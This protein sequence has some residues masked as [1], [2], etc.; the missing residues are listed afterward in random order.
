[1]KKVFLAAGLLLS[2]VSAQSV[3]AASPTATVSLNYVATAIATSTQNMSIKVVKNAAKAGVYSFATDAE[4]GFSGKTLG[5]LTSSSK[6]TPAVFAITAD[7]SSVLTLS[8][9]ANTVLSDGGGHSATMHI[10]AYGA[11]AEDFANT[12]FDTPIG[13]TDGISP[14]SATATSGVDGKYFVAV[15]PRYLGFALS[16][17]I[18][19]ASWAGTV[20]LTVDYQ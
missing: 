13:S 16:D 15:A 18:T 11:L 19:G 7:P 10:N 1:M 8:M 9:P 3:L 6:M 14:F 2:M 17:D 4:L 20:Q 12:Q 5:Q